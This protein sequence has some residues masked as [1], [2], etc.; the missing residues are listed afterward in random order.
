MRTSKPY[1]EHPAPAPS[2]RDTF[3]NLAA[4]TTTWWLIG[5]AFSLAIGAWL[6]ISHRAFGIPAQ[7]AAARNEMFVGA[8]AIVI[9]LISL[10]RP[11][12]PVRLGNAILGFWLLVSCWFVDG[13][14]LLSRWNGTAMAIALV[15]LSVPLGTPQRSRYAPR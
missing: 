1:I 12:R 6:L 2:R 13:A 7:F 10:F 15:L 11:T 8:A 4:H 5:A 14:T 3:S 9:T